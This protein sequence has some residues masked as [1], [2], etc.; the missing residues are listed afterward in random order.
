MT[1]TKRQRIV[2]RDSHRSM[3]SFRCFNKACPVYGTTVSDE[4]CAACPMQ[5]LKHKRPCAKI[6]R[7]YSECG[8]AEKALLKTTPKYPSLTMQL[9]TWKEAIKKWRAAGKP[10]RN[11]EEMRKILETHCHK[12]AW[13]DKDKRRCKGCGCRV[14]EGGVAVLNKIRM[15]TEH[16]PRDLW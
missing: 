8:A 5:V 16:C 15:K 14:T 11:K 13:Y 12:C 3:E 6:P 1:C 10:V 4:M 9:L 7:H 2:K